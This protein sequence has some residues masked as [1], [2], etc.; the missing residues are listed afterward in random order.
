MNKD[1]NTPTPYFLVNPNGLEEVRS[2]NRDI[3]SAVETLRQKMAELKEAMPIE[4]KLFT[5]SEA[6]IYL[7][8]SESFLRKDC[9]E[10]PRKNRTPG[11]DPLRI[12]DM[13][14]YTREDLDTWIDGHKRQRAHLA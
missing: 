10:G 3:H 5:L 2:L 1:D 12:G 7:A 13:I 6:A 14:R 9:A 8:V 11:P 4:K